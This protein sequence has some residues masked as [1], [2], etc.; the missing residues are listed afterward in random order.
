VSEKPL[1]DYTLAETVTLLGGVAN[2]IEKELAAALEEAA[3]LREEVAGLGMAN[4]TLTAQLVTER[5]LRAEM[6]TEL[7]EKAHGLELANIGLAAEL[8]EERR[9]GS[10]VVA[11][12]A[13][14]RARRTTGGTP[15]PYTELWSN[16]TTSPESA[17]TVDTP[18][19]KGGLL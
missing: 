14:E 16:V 19:V 13:D 18:S 15:P 3:Q 4:A 5:R 6:A 17:S 12:L 1:N 11:E 7:R 2:R 9:R 8:A 10:K